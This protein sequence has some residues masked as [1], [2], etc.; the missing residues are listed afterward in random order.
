MSDDL[1]HDKKSVAVFMDTVVNNFVG[2]SFLQVQVVNI[3]SDGPSSQFKNKF[4]AGFYHT[5][6]R[7]GLRIKRHFFATSHSKGVVDGLGGTVKRMVWGAVSTRK[8]SNVQDAVTFAKIAVQFCNSVNI[9][10]C[11][12]KDIDDYSSC[13]E[14]DRCFEQATPIPGISKI[15]CIEPAMK[16]QL[17]NHLY[18]SQPSIIH[19][20]EQSSDGEETH[21]VTS[22]T[23][24]TISSSNSSVDE[25]I[26][27]DTCRIY[28]TDFVND[29]GD[30]T[31]LCTH[32]PSPAETTTT[33][34][35][36]SNIQIQVGLPHNIRALVN[37][38]CTEFQ[39]PPYSSLLAELVF[40]NLD[41]D[42]PLAW[43][44]PITSTRSKCL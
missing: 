29:D 21:G 8:V 7:K 33:N 42:S 37:N 30:D 25:E 6:Q 17:R 28:D 36:E 31:P 24:T 38:Q 32:A 20:T 35:E 19:E 34:E 43:N 1:S 2:K 16:G 15:H 40:K 5:L 3:F 41:S 27:D 14:L 11:L 39:V 13:I 10:L 12:K 44:C 4:M 23:E 22:V 26:S 18:S 9:Q